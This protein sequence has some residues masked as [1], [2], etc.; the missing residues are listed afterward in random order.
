VVVALP[1]PYVRSDSRGVTARSERG[2]S[3]PTIQTR[4]RTPDCPEQVPGQDLQAGNVP[5]STRTRRPG[6]RA[7]AATATVQ[8][9]K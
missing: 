7:T 4:P 6:T 9:A 2:S 3:L 1:T 5:T 8:S